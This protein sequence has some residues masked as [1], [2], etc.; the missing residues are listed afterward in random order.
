MTSGGNVGCLID[1]PKPTQCA[2][3][4]KAPD[5]IQNESDV[6][7]TASDRSRSVYAKNER[8]P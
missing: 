1:L 5:A 2:N 8:Q 6:F 3:P 4:F 7:E